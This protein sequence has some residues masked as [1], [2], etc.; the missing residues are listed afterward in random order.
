MTFLKA[1]L[2]GAA[3]VTITACGPEG[4]PS[5]FETAPNRLLTTGEVTCQHYITD[6]VIWD[7]AITAPKDMDPQVAHGICKGEGKRMRRMRGNG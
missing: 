2:M 5:N 1:G 7:R 6:I 4:I 3:L